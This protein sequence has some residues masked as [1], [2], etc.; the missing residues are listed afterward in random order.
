MR[1]VNHPNVFINTQNVSS[2]DLWLWQWIPPLNKW[3]SAIP[4][5]IRDFLQNPEQEDPATVLEIAKR[6]LLCRRKFLVSVLNDERD[7]LP[8]SLLQIGLTKA[9]A[10]CRVTQYF[11]REDFQILIDK[12]QETLRQ[13][14]QNQNFDSIQKLREIFLLPDPIVASIQLSIDKLD[15]FQQIAARSTN[16]ETSLDR[17]LALLEAFKRLSSDDLAY[18]NPIPLGTGFLVGSSY[19]LTNHHVIPDEKRAT[20]CVAQFNFAED[21]LGY[22]Q[23]TVDY[24]F[25][26]DSVFETSDRLDYTLVKLKSNLSKQQAGYNF[27]WLQLIEKDAAVC[28]G[29]TKD[30]IEDLKV[31]IK[32]INPNLEVLREDELGESVIIVHHPKGLQKKIDITNNRVIQGGLLRNYLRYEIDSDYG[33]SGSPVFNTK[34]DLVALHHA[35]IPTS[36]SSKRLIQQG[37]RISRLVED[38][39]K[40]SFRNPKLQ[41]FIEDFVITS[42]QLKYPPLPAAL[43]L[44][45]LKD[46]IQVDSTTT[47]VF[48]AFSV[49]AWVNL[50]GQQEKS[51]IFTAFCQEEWAEEE[52]TLGDVVLHCYLTL[53]GELVV[54]RKKVFSSYP[55]SSIL[56]PANRLTLFYPKRYPIPPSIRQGDEGAK[57]KAFKQFFNLVSGIEPRLEETE[58]FNLE[59]TEQVKKFQKNHTDMEGNP[60]NVDGIVG[61]QTLDALWRTIQFEQGNTNSAVKDIKYLLSLINIA[62]KEPFS[63]AILEV[64][65]QTSE[66]FCEQTK[67]AVELFQKNRSL[68]PTGIIDSE[69][70]DSL[71]VY[72]LSIREGNKAQSVQD[73]Q[74]LLK[75]AGYL[76]SEF[77]TTKTFNTSTVAAVK[78][79][80]KLNKLED[81][82]IVGQRTLTALINDKFYTYEL[83]AQKFSWI[84]KEDFIKQF[85]RDCNLEITG[86]ADSSTIEKMVEETKLSFGAYSHVAVTYNGEMIRLLVNGKE[87]IFSKKENANPKDGYKFRNDQLKLSKMPVRFLIGAYAETAEQI[88]DKHSFHF[89]GNIA[90]LRIWKGDCAQET[91]IE[92]QSNDLFK[93]LIGNE[94]DLIGYWRFEEAEIFEPK[95]PDAENSQPIRRDLPNQ[96]THPELSGT[97]VSRHPRSALATHFPA[98][99]LPFGLEFN[100]IEDTLSYSSSQFY[101]SQTDPIHSITIEAWV[102]YTFGD[103]FIVDQRSH[104]DQVIFSVGFQDERLFV[105]FQGGGKATK[106]E[107]VPQFPRDLVWHHVAVTWNSESEIRMYLDGRVQ[108]VVVLEADKTKSIVIQGR[109]MAIAQFQSSIDLKNSTLFIGKREKEENYFHLAIAEVRIWK[110]AHTQDRIKTRQFCR[111][112]GNGEGDETDL[113]GYWRLDNNDGQ[114]SPIDNDD[115]GERSHSPKPYPPPPSSFR[116]G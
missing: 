113:V 73:L 50:T 11:T 87:L 96:A 63:E 95:N 71:W 105:K 24:E 108:P 36:T 94:P 59:D 93:R 8:S 32:K 64:L 6:R 65:R 16:P 104:T 29:L 7:V 67:S 107:M 39:K 114:S 44:D 20:K 41:S 106:I 61:S 91:E 54:A 86:F 47:D 102:N 34:W 84:V 92:S 85:Q 19:L 46:Y 109:R 97:L 89:Q 42:E 66:E 76:K 75:R 103:G 3:L 13:Q 53:E 81:D 22:T 30:E 51:T 77:P 40:Q 38:L 60:L 17:S 49:E 26:A 100:E 110:T 74:S 33:S 27:G 9:M 78:E 23:S 55:V 88:L 28:P 35:A 70:L 115:K 83:R 98:L 4:S 111:L 18:M 25:D 37:V 10:V 12:I 48:K 80:Q 72:G 2:A 99:P 57:I 15:N 112:R 45:G 82:G 5:H 31:E 116:K 14:Q 43:E 69:T 79:F 101:S 1:S 56:F 21:A 52:S 62:L 58:K 90:E 68:K